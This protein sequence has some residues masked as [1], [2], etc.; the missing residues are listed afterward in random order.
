[1]RADV[2]R[3]GV[4]ETQMHE[5]NGSYNAT[6]THTIHYTYDA[7]GRLIVEDFDFRRGGIT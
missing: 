1:V 6:D 5:A 4:V 2:K 3:T 7:R